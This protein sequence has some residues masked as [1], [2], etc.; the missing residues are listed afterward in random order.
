[1]VKLKVRLLDLTGSGQ[2]GSSFYDLPWGRGTSVPDS[3]GEELGGRW[4]E[5]EVLRG[6]FFCAWVLMNIQFPLALSTE[7]T[8]FWIMVLSSNNWC[9]LRIAVVGNV[10]KIMLKLR[11]REGRERVNEVSRPDTAED[12]KPCV[13]KE[14]RT[15]GKCELC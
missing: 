5:A 9:Q 11:T 14:R 2:E 13:R 15:Q 7:H 3:L 4:S 8:T 6:F 1:M 12:N 10:W